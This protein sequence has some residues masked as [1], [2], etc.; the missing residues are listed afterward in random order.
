MALG[1]EV[2]R[3]RYARPSHGGRLCTRKPDR[4]LVCFPKGGDLSFAVVHLR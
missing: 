4:S 3:V 2:I 1:T